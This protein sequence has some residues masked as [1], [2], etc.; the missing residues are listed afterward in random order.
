MAA[1]AGPLLLCCVPPTIIPFTV[2][3]GRNSPS[4]C[5]LTI[6]LVLLKTYQAGGSSGSADTVG[7]GTSGGVGGTIWQLQYVAHGPSVSAGAQ[8]DSVGS[9][10]CSAQRCFGLD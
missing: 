7:A 8:A 3:L 4:I 2:R 9:D 6:L 1:L 5:F 10:T